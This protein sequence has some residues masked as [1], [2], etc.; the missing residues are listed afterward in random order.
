SA[1]LGELAG[2]FKVTRQIHLGLEIIRCKGWNREMYQP[3]WQLP[4]VPTSPAITNFAAM[5]FYPGI[6]LLEATNLSEGR[7]SAYSFTAIAAPW[8]QPDTLHDS[9]SA[10]SLETVQAVPVQFTPNAPQVKYPGQLCKGV[11]LLP[12]AGYAISPVQFGMHAIRLIKDRYPDHFRWQPYPTLVN[13]DGSGHLEKLLGRSGMTALFELPLPK[14]HA[15]VA[16]LTRCAEWV[17]EIN[18]HLLY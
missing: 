18:P 3:D 16:K 9:L 13:P 2:Y 4:F 11:Q 7:G 14:F 10:I 15:S 5:L 1:T 12:A 17:N 8:L 6:C